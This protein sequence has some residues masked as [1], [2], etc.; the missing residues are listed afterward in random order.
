MGPVVRRDARWRAAQSQDSNMSEA[1]PTASGQIALS[2]TAPSGALNVIAHFLIRRRILLSAIVFAAIIIENL[3]V[4]TKPRD[5]ANLGDPYGLLGWLFVLVGL[6][7]R[8]WAAGVLRKDRELTVTGPYRLIR[9]PLYFGSFLMMTGFCVLLGDVDNFF[10]IL[11]PVI[12]L[13]TIKVRQEERWLAGL[14]PEPFAAYL[15]RTPR[16]IPRLAWVDVRSPWNWA[17]WRASREYKALVATVI[18][19]VA[20]KVWQLYAAAL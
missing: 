13:Y 7:L 15:R 1:S 3:V 2:T 9:N 16:F 17:Q 6:G 20:L 11:A 5:L 18:A 4:G 19:L 12:L 8:S 14:F 10:L